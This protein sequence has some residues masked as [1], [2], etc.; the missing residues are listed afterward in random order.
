M[1]STKNK[2]Y[3]ILSMVIFGTIGMFRK[4]IP[5]PSGMLAMARGF[6]GTASL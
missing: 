1:N 5:L 3:L 4:F 2:L 6:I